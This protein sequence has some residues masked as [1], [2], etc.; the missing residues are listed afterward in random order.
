VRTG[1]VCYAVA[2]MPRLD[3]TAIHEAGHAVVALCE[4]CTFDRVVLAADG[5]VLGTVHN[6]KTMLGHEHGARIKL[7]GVVAERLCRRAWRGEL[8][9]AAEGDLIG[10]GAFFRENDAGDLID[11]NIAAT[12][13]TL[14]ENWTAVE[15]IARALSRRK[16]LSYDVVREIWS[17]AASMP[18]KTPPGRI[19]DEMWEPLRKRVVWHVANP[20]GMKAIFDPLDVVSVWDLHQ[21]LTAA[22]TSR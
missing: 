1:E 19:D 14:L 20:D 13:E 9:C 16:E 3:S 2:F 10:V 15:K 11:W 17:A 5:D 4:G 21:K 22:S 7:A 8:I 12:H 6:V 18:L